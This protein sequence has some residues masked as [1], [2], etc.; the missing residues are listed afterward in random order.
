[1]KYFIHIPKTAGTSLRSGV[2]GIPRSG[3]HVQPVYSMEDY[4][5]LMGL[6]GCKDRQ[7]LVFGHFSFGLHR[8]LED[9]QAEYATVLRDPVERVVSLYHHHL[10]FESSPYHS[11]LIERKLSLTDFVE[12]CITPE[13]NNEIVRNFSASYGWL[14]LFCDRVANRW[15]H[16]TRGLPT[17]QINER[18]RLRRALRNLQMH[19]KHVGSL[20]R[21]FD[22]ASFI[23][24]WTQMEPG[25]LALPRENTRLGERECLT[26][27]ERR[28][29][30]N[31]NQLDLELYERMVAQG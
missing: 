31:A 10:R 27:A 4:Q 3:L 20:E 6:R 29:I 18:F 17:R 30:E 15:W 22:T 24:S 9:D 14:P 2:L 26:D 16:A 8:Q 12:A 23:E 1:M 28:V 19:F 5:S 7:V 13:T 21:L 25:S 11:L